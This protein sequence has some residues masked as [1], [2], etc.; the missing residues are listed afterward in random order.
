VRVSS[1]DGL[2]A[3]QPPWDGFGR[4][5]NNARQPLS[6]DREAA[7]PAAA[8]RVA[9]TLSSQRQVMLILSKTSEHPSHKNQLAELSCAI[10][11]PTGA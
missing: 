2:F 10:M 8:P 7:A 3:K 1:V 6:G 5:V 4:N 9:S 11:R